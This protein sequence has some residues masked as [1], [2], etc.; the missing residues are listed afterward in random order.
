MFRN[1]PNLRYPIRETGLKLRVDIEKPNIVCNNITL[2]AAN[3]DKYIGLVCNITKPS[4][5][6][7]LTCANVFWKLTH[8]QIIIRGSKSGIHTHE[9]KA[10]TSMWDSSCYHTN[11]GINASLKVTNWDDLATT[12]AYFV[13]HGEGER[14]HRIS[15]YIQEP[16]FSVAGRYKPTLICI[17]LAQFMSSRLPI[18]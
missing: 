4:K 12:K 3:I 1:V 8:E 7:K 17:V 9:T 10:N 13:R 14:A 16:V 2:V 5:N 15:V 18:T 11:H 6:V